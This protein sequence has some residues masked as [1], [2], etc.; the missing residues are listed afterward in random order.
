MLTG[1]WIGKTNKVQ[2]CDMFDSYVLEDL[3]S[4]SKHLLTE[5]SPQQA[6]SIV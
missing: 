1:F 2:C 6:L 4:H 5:L 3:Y